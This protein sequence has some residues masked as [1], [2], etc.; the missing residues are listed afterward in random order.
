M[1]NIKLPLWIDVLNNTAYSGWQSLVPYK[2]IILKQ[3]DKIDIELHLVKKSSYDNKVVEE[4][5]FTNDMNIK[6]AIGNIN[7]KPTF[8]YFTLTYLGDSCKIL[9]TDSQLQV[10]NKLN[11]LNSIINSG[12]VSVLIEDGNYRI[13]FNE[14][15]VRS[16]FSIN[17]SNLIPLSSVIL[18]RLI[19]GN[20]NKSDVQDFKFKCIPFAFTDESVYAD[21]AT[22][23]FNKVENK[24][25]VVS[26]N[27]N[28]KSGWFK[29]SDG[30]NETDEILIN[31]SSLDLENK[32]ISSGIQDQNNKFEVFKLSQYT[33]TIRQLTGL[34]KNLTTVSDLKSFSAK[35]LT[36]NLNTTQLEY[37]ISSEKLLNSKI[38]IEISNLDKKQTIYQ[39]D[40][41][42]LNDLIDSSI[43]DPILMPS[44][45]SQTD[46]DNLTIR[47][48]NLELNSIQ[49]NIQ[50][51]LNNDLLIY[52]ES[53]EKWVNSQLNITKINGGN[54]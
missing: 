30:S 51:P 52:D 45:A 2:S 44:P 17:T 12:G 37:L 9:L 46:L 18:N 27:P 31:S 48:N 16:S 20:S 25:W 10:Q 1:E 6:I 14:N 13:S 54:F 8:G 38:E 22:L 39:G 21:N 4:V 41:I 19:E 49:T 47:V 11:Q 42:V 3:G 34:E 28:P 29:I 33:W 43:Y 5:E 24:N 15:G 7:E 26:I 35:I 53:Q 40:V 36:L 23:S 50:N 32:L